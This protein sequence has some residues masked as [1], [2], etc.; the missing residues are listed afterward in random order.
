MYFEPRYF[1]ANSGHCTKTSSVNH[2][3]IRPESDIV[4]TLHTDS[5]K[6]ILTAHEIRSTFELSHAMAQI[7]THVPGP[8]H[9]T[10]LGLCIS[11]MLKLATEAEIVVKTDVSHDCP[12]SLDLGTVTTV[13]CGSNCAAF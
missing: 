7:G 6:T 13:A 11:K 8:L 10:N 9:N 5:T 4:A 2:S 12:T 1:S 3:K